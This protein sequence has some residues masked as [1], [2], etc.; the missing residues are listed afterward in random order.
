MFTQFHLHNNKMAPY[1]IQNII[2]NSEKTIQANVLINASSNVFNGHFPGRPILPGVYH[3]YITMN[4]LKKFYDS[5]MTFNACANIKFLNY[6]DPNLVTILNYDI[7]IK[8]I[9]DSSYTLN[10]IVKNDQTVFC[11]MQNLH[12]KRI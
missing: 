3:L 9:N 2:N 6:I 8:N 1:T 10:V 5:N 12:V 11:K 4:I 7:Y